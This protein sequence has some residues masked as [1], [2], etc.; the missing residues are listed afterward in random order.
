MS[1][2]ILAGEAP[3]SSMLDHAVRGQPLLARSG[4]LMALAMI[5]TA[6]ALGLDTRLLNGI[7][8]W[9]KPLKF[10]ASLAVHLL[11]VAW[12][13][14]C[15]PPDIRN[16]RLSRGLAAALA[17]A[18]LFEIAYI[19]LQ[20]ARGEAS[21]FNRTT[22]VAD[23][24]YSLMGAGALVLV[25]TTAAIGAQI[26][27][28]GERRKPLVFAAGIGLILGALLGGASGLYMSAQTAHWV[29]G[30]ASDAGGLPIVGWSRL[31]GDL[32]VAHF[33]GLHLMQA[34]PVAAWLGGRLLRERLQMPAILVIAALG[35]LL[36]LATLAQAILGRPFLA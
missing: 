18:A 13:M 21:H 11:T 14:L 29:G 5:P 12:L 17:V 3:R 19:A 24:M 9:I 30:V 20:A 31:G 32:R 8:V 26:L 10:E 35:T 27:R 36:T 6:L 23:L 33:F 7:G 22:P 16:G 34:L 1:T 25:G 2:E 15:L 28:H 4:M